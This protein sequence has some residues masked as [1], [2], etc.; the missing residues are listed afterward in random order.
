MT[1]SMSALTAPATYD[2]LSSEFTNCPRA[3][4]ALGELAAQ[5]QQMMVSLR[6]VEQEAM[7]SQS[8]ANAIKGLSRTRT[9]AAG[10][11]LR[12]KDG[13]R[14]YPKSWSGNTPLGGFALD[15]AA[16]LRHVD[17]K[18]EARKLIQRITQGTLRASEAWTDGRHAEDAKNVE[19]DFELAVALATATEGAARSTVLKVTHAEP[20]HGFGMAST[21][22]RLRP[23]VIA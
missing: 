14:L 9:E 5:W 22:R 21:G 8:Q 16:W 17:P 15:V 18:H 3:V 12:L 11:P 6:R 20:S 10:D 4:A 1:A 2:L 23:P 13:E 19:L 7:S